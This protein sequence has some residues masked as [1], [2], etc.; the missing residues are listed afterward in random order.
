MQADNIAT[1]HNAD[2]VCLNSAAEVMHEQ[3]AF[4]VQIAELQHCNAG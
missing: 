4:A 1:G 2:D 3:Q